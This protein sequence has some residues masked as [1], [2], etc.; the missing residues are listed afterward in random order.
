MARRRPPDLPYPRAS[1]RFDVTPGLSQALQ[2]TTDRGALVLGHPD[3]LEGRSAG[4]AE[5]DGAGVRCQHGMI[6]GK[7]LAA[8]VVPLLHGGAVQMEVND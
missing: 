1:G 2:L 4:D 8:A 3:E 7:A 6:L 5:D